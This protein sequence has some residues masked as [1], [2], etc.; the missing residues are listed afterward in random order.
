MPNFYPPDFVHLRMP[1]NESHVQLIT[2]A[3]GSSTSGLTTPS[4]SP[5]FSGPPPPQYAES[6]N[7]LPPPPRIVYKAA[8]GKSILQYAESSNELPPPPRIVYKA[9]GGKS[10]LQEWV[11]FKTGSSTAANMH[12]AKTTCTTR[13]HKS[14]TLASFSEQIVSYV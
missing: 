11:S 2:M 5:V 14:K 6:S 1:N 3:Q 13:K 10:I 4:E 9:A 12:N 8:G 7:E